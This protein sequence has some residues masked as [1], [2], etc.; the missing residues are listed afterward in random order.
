MLKAFELEGEP[1]VAAMTLS[2]DWGENSDGRESESRKRVEGE[3][4]G[5]RV[6]SLI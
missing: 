4:S 6:R 5:A 1:G 3:E 2:V